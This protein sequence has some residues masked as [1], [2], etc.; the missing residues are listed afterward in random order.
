VTDVRP[1]LTSALDTFGLDATVTP[2]GS[3]AVPTRA[4]WLPSVTAQGP[5]G[6]EYQRAEQQR[7]LVIPIEGLPLM[8][9]GTAVSVP[10]FEGGVVMDWKVDAADRLDF[11]HYRAVMVPA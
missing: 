10:E 4:F 2:P 11:D 8:P 5:A 7:V 9:R 3:S 6:R 1:L